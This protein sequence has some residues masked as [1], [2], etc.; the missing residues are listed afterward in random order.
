[1]TDHPDLPPPADNGQDGGLD[2][3]R[4]LVKAAFERALISGKPNWDEMTSAV[5]KNRLLDLTSRQFSEDRYGSPSFIHLVRRV[6]DLLQVVDDRP[7]FRLKIR[8]PITEQAGTG[9]PLESSPLPIA[10]ATLPAI[11]EGNWRNVR[12]RNDLWRAIMDNASGNTYVLDSDTG[13]ARPKRVT[14]IGLPE[15]PTVSQQIVHSWRREFVESLA[16][17]IKAEFADELG[18]WVESNGRQ[19]DLPRRV[20][21]RWAAFTKRK[22]DQILRDW[23]REQGESPPQDLISVAQGHVIPSSEAIDEVV[24]ARQLRDLIIHAVRTMTYEELV[25]ISLPASV[26]LRSSEAKRIMND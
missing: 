25:K 14:D 8:V 19:S 7:P 13:L 21:G 4:T 24:Q 17:P 1:M 6:P 5:L 15:F 12:I 20:R 16:V 11:A 2:E 22:V 10:D 23:F 26:L 18:A 3:F 9:T